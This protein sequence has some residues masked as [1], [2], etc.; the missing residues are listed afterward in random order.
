M[1]TISSCDVAL[2]QAAEN[3]TK[4]VRFSPDGSCLLSCSEDNRLRVFEVPHDLLV[5][6]APPEGG[7][8]EGKDGE[9]RPLT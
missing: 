5:M 4:G 2:V 6:T 7:T 9:V 8:E 3:L 1:L